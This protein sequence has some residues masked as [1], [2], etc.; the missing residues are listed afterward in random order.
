MIQAR[1]KWRRLLRIA[2]YT[3]L[4][5]VLPEIIV[6]IV[7]IEF[8]AGDTWFAWIT[9]V[10]AVL[11]IGISY[12]YF[13]FEIDDPLLR[14][15]ATVGVGTGAAALIGY[16]DLTIT[17]FSAGRTASG[18]WLLAGGAVLLLAGTGVVFRD[19]IW[20]VIRAIPR[21]NDI[22][23]P[24]ASLPVP[25]QVLGLAV[26]VA[27][28]ALALTLAGSTLSGAILSLLLL[29]G[30]QIVGQSAA[31]RL[32]RPTV[33]TLANQYR[34]AESLKSRLRGHLEPSRDHEFPPD[35][36]D[37]YWEREYARREWERREYEE[38]R[39]RFEAMG[40][41]PEDSLTE[42][43][44]R[45]R[46]ITRPFA[47]R[48]ATMVATEVT[49]VH[50]VVLAA[51]WS[52]LTAVLP[53]PILRRTERL[54]WWISLSRLGAAAALG[55]VVTFALSPLPVSTKLL[56]VAVAA[57]TCV[58]AVCA[59]R[60]QVTRAC[61][62]RAAAFG[63]YRFDLVRALHLPRPRSQAEFVLLGDR[64]I[65][66][67]QDFVGNQVI[68]WDEASV[69]ALQ[70]AAVDSIRDE[71]S[72]AI[73]AKVDEQ[74]TRAARRQQELLQDISLLDIGTNELDRISGEVVR[75][76]VPD[77]QT[78]LDEKIDILGSQLR[79]SV[80][81]S[82]TTA[83]T[84]PA[85]ANFTGFLAVHPAENKPVL[86][87]DGR[88]VAVAGSV[89]LLAVSVFADQ[90]ARQ[91]GPERGKDG[92]ALFILEPV[93]IEEGTTSHQVPFDIVVDSATLSPS[94]HRHSIRVFPVRG[95]AQFALALDVQEA[96]EHEAWLQLYQAGRLI[97]SVVLA[98]AARPEGGR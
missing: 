95:E 33:G 50:G 36:N 57:L 30:C 20:E 65:G 12:L 14:L 27:I 22:P 24:G 19:V 63:V 39:H 81:E 28:S 73:V 59:G 79:T 31:M 48:T 5:I 69:P 98:V 9:I 75:Q 91:A 97:Q 26:A 93:N 72:T 32:F 67:P 90:R 2:G 44:A 55:A 71:L 89:V 88:I 47:P 18:W 74:L 82:M 60:V 40:R 3:A 51:V 85:L 1:S 4:A 43:L 64:L 25:I 78:R 86:A 13:E 68:E 11:A 58:W 17:Q 21:G 29:S 77:L 42:D 38:E 37:P 53:A 52:R 54:E 16:T 7:A 76:V 10:A 80:D 45:T 23:G 94:P 34:A 41:W 70:P 87:E 8:M 62:A 83:M 66:R 61:D 56:T 84:G 96:G 6:A 49:R 15:L 35:S 46:A 92:E